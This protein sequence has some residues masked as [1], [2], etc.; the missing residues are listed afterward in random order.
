MNAV[1]MISRPRVWRHMAAS[2]FGQHAAAAQF[3]D[4]SWW[5]RGARHVLDFFG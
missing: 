1:G 2:N 4:A 3:A 5:I